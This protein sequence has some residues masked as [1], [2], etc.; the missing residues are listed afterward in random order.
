[1]AADAKAD[2]NA[3]AA[4]YGR[5]LAAFS[6]HWTNGSWSKRW[7]E[8]SLMIPNEEFRMI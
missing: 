6:S 3:D 5:F 7:N 8:V 2:A 1:M 4:S